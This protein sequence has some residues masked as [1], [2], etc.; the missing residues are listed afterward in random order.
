MQSSTL[1]VIAQVAPPKSVTGNSFD[2]VEATF[3]ASNDYS[4]AD[5][6][7]MWEVI[8][9]VAKSGLALPVAFSFLTYSLSNNSVPLLFSDTDL[10]AVEVGADLPVMDVTNSIDRN[11]RNYIIDSAGT[12]PDELSQITY[13][14]PAISKQELS[15]YYNN[16][17]TCWR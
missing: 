8:I 13:T 16:I 14:L 2:L 10:I 3:D 17:H 15:F 5:Y 11:L 6:H 12:L 9:N 1:L 7:R 4:P